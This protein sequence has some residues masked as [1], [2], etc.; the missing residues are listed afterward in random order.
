MEGA[1]IECERD[2]QEGMA[3]ISLCNIDDLEIQYGYIDSQGNI[4]VPCIYSEAGTFND[5]IARVRIGPDFPVASVDQRMLPDR[6]GYIDKSGE[7]VIPLRYDDL[8]D[9]HEGLAAAAIKGK[10]GFINRVGELVIPFEYD[11]AKFLVKDWRRSS[12]K[13][14]GEFHNG[15][16]KV[17]INVGGGLFDS[18]DGFIN[19]KGEEVIPCQYPVADDFHYTDGE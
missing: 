15:F 19:S 18:I 1:Q 3:T 10:W 17:S 8:G 7:I 12:V 4:V 11:D 2:F 16:A 14:N 9:F 13:R 6:Y 5:G